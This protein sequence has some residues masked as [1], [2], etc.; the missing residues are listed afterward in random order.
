M[1]FFLMQ[2]LEMIKYGWLV[3]IQQAKEKLDEKWELTH[4]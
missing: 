3:F 2:E 4:I 1:S